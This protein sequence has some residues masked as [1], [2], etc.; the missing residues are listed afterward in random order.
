MIRP[1]K[2]HL[3]GR[4]WGWPHDWSIWVRKLESGSY[5]IFGRYGVR[6]YHIP[7]LEDDD[8]E[9]VNNWAEET[10]EELKQGV[11]CPDWRQTHN[12]RRP[13]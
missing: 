1:F 9:S 8:L 11:W 12:E 13:A 5:R 7:C 6:L 4:K 10:Y 3:K 2:K